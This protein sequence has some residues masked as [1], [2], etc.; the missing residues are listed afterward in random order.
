MNRNLNL[1]HLNEAQRTAVTTVDGP[2]LVLAGAGSGKTRVIV[3]RALYLMQVHAVKPSEILAV[4]FTNKAAHEMRQRIARRVGGDYSDQMAICTFHAFGLSFLRAE[5]AATRKRFS[6]IDRSDQIGAVRE[7][8]RTLRASGREFDPAAIV[9]RISLRKNQLIGMRLKDAQVAKESGEADDEYKRMTDEV[10]PK[11]QELLEAWAAFDFDDLLLKPLLLMRED[12][13]CAKRWAARYRYV[14]VDEYQDSNLAQFELVRQLTSG[15]GNLCVVGDD[16]QSIYAWRGAS[17]RNILEF[18]RIYPHARIVTLDYNYRSTQ[19]ILDQANR[20]ISRNQRRRTKMLRAVTAGGDPVEYHQFESPEDEAEWVVGQIQ[21]IEGGRAADTAILYRSNLQ[22][23]PFEEKLREKQVPYC[24]VGGVA[25][26]DNK[27]VKDYLG[28]LRVLQNP[29]DDLSLRRILNVPARGIGPATV[30][31]IEQVAFQQHTS[32]YRAIR[33]LVE[34][35]DLS[36][37]IATA[38]MGFLELFESLRRMLRDQPPMDVAKQLLVRSGLKD[39]LR[40][41]GMRPE[42]IRRREGNLDL[43]LQGIETYLSRSADRD[44]QSYVDLLLFDA[45]ERDRDDPDAS[46]RLMT[47]HSAKG[48]EFKTVFLVGWEDGILPHRRSLPAESRITDAVAGDIDEER[49]LAYVGLT[50]ARE[51]AVISRAKCRVRFGKEART[52][53]S[54][55]LDELDPSTMLVKDWSLPQDES[56]RQQVAKRELSKI[57]ELLGDDMI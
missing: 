7:I 55:F 29:H 44:L 33:H 8:L 19:P 51:R 21:R 1:N 18:D 20:L 43:L 40:Q 34:Q 26:F 25:F 30:Q 38:L 22:A 12:P 49:R 31:R 9:S 48:L 17:P 3:E 47:L 50:R 14:M 53:P 39:Y 35:D 28:Y 2:L 54:R 13:E 41:S 4:T 15:Y 46:V 56:Q 6:M 36:P 23:R 45:I 16:D 27:E 24:V 42:A 37:S 5:F 10:L 52:T 32:F 11:Y 57:F